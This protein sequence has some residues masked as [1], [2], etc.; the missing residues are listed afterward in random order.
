LS[1]VQA[2]FDRI[3]L[4]SQDSWDHNQH[5]HSFLLKHIPAHC[6]A[7]LDVG[8]GT[9]TLSRLLAERSDQVVALDLSPAM[10]EAAKEC[11]KPYSNIDFRIVDAMSWAFPVEAFDCITSIATLHHMTTEEMLLKMKRALN[12]DGTLAI[13]DLYESAGLSD[14]LAGTAA[15]PVS[16]ALRWIKT[17][18]FREPR[19]VREAWAEHGRNDTY[20]SL[21]Q[22]RTVC[23]KVLPGA[24]V[25]RHLL[26][27]YS[28]IWRKVV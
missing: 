15:M 2:D 27:R 11:S 19:Q 16:L 5:Y 25:R 14:L 10:I 22:V 18:R 13:L 4:L 12:V 17:G 26:W 24:Q 23:R 1:T 8:C 20:L 7:V 21:T 28:L 9:G 3:A 6:K